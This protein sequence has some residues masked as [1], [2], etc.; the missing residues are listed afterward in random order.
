MDD[1]NRR[2]VS[3]WRTCFS[4]N[5]LPVQVDTSRIFYADTDFYYFESMIFWPGHE[6]NYTYRCV[7]EVGAAAAAHADLCALVEAAAFAVTFPNGG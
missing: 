4:D 2:P 7:H 3:L 5:V 1:V 6:L